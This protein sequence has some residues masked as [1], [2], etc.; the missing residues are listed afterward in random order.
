[1]RRRPGLRAARSIRATDEIRFDQIHLSNSPREQC[2][3]TRFD[4][5]P[6]HPAVF[7]FRFP[8]GDNGLS[9]AVYAHPHKLRLP[10]RVLTFGP[11]FVFACPY[12]FSHIAGTLSRTPE[13]T[14]WPDASDLPRSNIDLQ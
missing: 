2:S 1:M 4:W 9:L 13:V 14:S 3:A 12:P 6:G 7:S 11:I 5:V 10:L 8:K